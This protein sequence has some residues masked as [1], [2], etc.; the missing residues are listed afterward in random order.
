MWDVI[1]VP[2]FCAISEEANTYKD[3][4]I[5]IVIYIDEL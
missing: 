5:S 3:K 2:P 4:K 1:C